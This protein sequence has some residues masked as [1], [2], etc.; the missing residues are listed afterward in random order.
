MAEPPAGVSVAL[1]VQATSSLN[2]ST[3]VPLVETFGALLAIDWLLSVGA[4]S[5]GAIVR[6][7]MALIASLVLLDKSSKAPLSV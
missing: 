2:V 1:V 6:K 7:V 5:S 3:I 4:V